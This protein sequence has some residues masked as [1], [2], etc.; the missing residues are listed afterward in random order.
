MPVQLLS[1]RR[2]LP[3]MS[4]WTICCRGREVWALSTSCSISPSARA[5]T[6]LERSSIGWFRSLFKS[7]FTSA[8]SLRVPMQKMIW[9]MIWFAHRRTFA[10]AT[11]GSWHGK[12]TTITIALFTTGFSS[13]TWCV[14]LIGK[15][16]S[17]EVHSTSPGAWHYFWYPVTRTK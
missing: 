2:G 16:A 10:K 13:W 8:P 5:A 11:R 6:A 17:L 9:I 15:V 3:M 12:S 4:S 1:G 14:R 7:K